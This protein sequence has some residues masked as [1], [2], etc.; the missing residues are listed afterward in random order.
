MGYYSLGNNASGFFCLL[1]P[2][3]FVELWFLQWRVCGVTWTRHKRPHSWPPEAQV[4]YLGKWWA[5]EY[6]PTSRRH[7]HVPGPRGEK[8]PDGE[9]W[10]NSIWSPMHCSGAFVRSLEYELSVFPWSRSLHLPWLEKKVRYRFLQLIRGMMD[11]WTV[12]TFW[13]FWMLLLLTFTDKFLDMFSVLSYRPGN[14]I[15]GSRG[16]SVICTAVTYT[17]TL[18][19]YKPWNNRQWENSFLS[20]MAC[21]K[22]DLFI[23]SSDKGRRF[24]KV[25]CYWKQAKRVFFGAVASNVRFYKEVETDGWKQDIGFYS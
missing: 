5:L 12:S 11:P 24:G 13:L 6:D 3:W 16:N 15:A 20:F 23:L 14:G 9:K 17:Y 4:Y 1:L 22:I 18:Y 2:R 19:T 21:L 10:L 7:L 8:I 25:W